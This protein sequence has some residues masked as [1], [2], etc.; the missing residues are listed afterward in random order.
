MRTK[1][2]E[3]ADRIDCRLYSVL[4]GVEALWSKAKEQRDRDQTKLLRDTLVAL[5][6]ARW[7]I[8]SLMSEEDRKM[9]T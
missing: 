5:R 3:D 7:R 8:R 1:L 6:C 4:V 9:T 2:Q